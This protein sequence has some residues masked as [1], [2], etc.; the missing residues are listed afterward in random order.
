MIFISH[1]YI[2]DQVGNSALVGDPKEVLEVRS[3][4]G[5]STSL[6]PKQQE[7]V[8]SLSLLLSFFPSPDGI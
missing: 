7:H 1:V 5:M 3:H 8:M 4:N 6:P 2:P